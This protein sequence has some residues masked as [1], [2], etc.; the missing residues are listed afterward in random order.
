MLP[1]KIIFSGLAALLSLGSAPAALAQTLLPQQ[2]VLLDSRQNSATPLQGNVLQNIVFV[3][4][5][6]PT[7]HFA[8]RW[9]W[10]SSPSPPPAPMTILI[11]NSQA[12]LSAEAAEPQACGQRCQGSLRLP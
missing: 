10:H 1:S 8:G 9:G 6:A 5:S 3:V 11:L 2:T 4:P 7:R 12:N